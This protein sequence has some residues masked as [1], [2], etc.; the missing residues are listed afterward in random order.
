MEN[1]GCRTSAPPSWGSA[2]AWL[3]AQTRGMS[4][5]FGDSWKEPESARERGED[6]E[7]LPSLERQNSERV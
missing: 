1:L 5:V 6:P 2:T 7:M 3:R 4:M